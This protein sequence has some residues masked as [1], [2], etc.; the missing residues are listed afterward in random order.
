[1]PLPR[2]MSGASG[3]QR[4]GT[5]AS[6]WTFGPSVQ[7]SIALPSARLPS[8]THRPHQRNGRSG[9]RCLTS[10][11]PS[12]A[13][14]PTPYW[15]SNRRSDCLR[16]P[17]LRGPS[18]NGMYIPSPSRATR[19]SDPAQGAPTS[20]RRAAATRC[21]TRWTNRLH[22]S[23]SISC[24]APTVSAFVQ[25]VVHLTGGIHSLAWAGPTTGTHRLLPR[26]VSLNS[27]CAKG[28]SSRASQRQRP[29]NFAEPP[30]ARSYSQESI[31]F[32]APYVRKLTTPSRGVTK[33]SSPSTS[34]S[35]Y[36]PYPSASPA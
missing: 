11:G 30:A 4:C 5:P 35:L 25:P 28:V 18:A 17:R 34:L 1:M 12:V 8:T 9:F 14:N 20:Q 23:C 36:A 7:H 13:E 26:S 29:R 33:S 6:L 10:F 22:G 32:V 3:Q 21:R 27:S 19:S 24:G 2:S 15:P 16:K 31:L